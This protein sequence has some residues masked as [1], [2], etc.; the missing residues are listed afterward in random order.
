MN[1]AYLALVFVVLFLYTAFQ[2]PFWVLWAY[3]V[4]G[5]CAWVCILAHGKNYGLLRTVF[6]WLPWLIFGR[7]ID[8]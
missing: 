5:F 3:P 8:D 4:I 7:R 1:G 2:N 6:M